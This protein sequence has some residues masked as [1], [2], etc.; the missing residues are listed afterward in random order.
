MHKK[1]QQIERLT[2]SLARAAIIRTHKAQLA[3]QRIYKP[4]RRM[5]QDIKT[6][7]K[8]LK[9]R[10]AVGF[11]ISLIVVAEVIP[12]F[13]AFMNEKAYAFED[14][15]QLL[16]KTSQAMA[17]KL[18][19]NTAEQTFNFNANYSLGSDPKAGGAK[20]IATAHVDPLKG[21]NVSDPVNKT[22]FGLKP[23]FQL[24]QGEKRENRVVYPLQN[25]SG[26]LVYSMEA[27][28]VKEDILLRYA[29]DNKMKFEYELDFGDS[30]EA[31]LEQD[32]SI[33][34]YG[35]SLPI[36]GSVSTGSDKDVEL[37][38]K[39]RQNAKKDKLMFTIPAPFIKETNKT[40]SDIKSHYE[41]KGKLLTL[42]VDGL[43]KGNYPLTIDPS[44]YVTSAEQFMYG[45]NDSNIEFDTSTALIQKGNLT[46][47]RI[48][49]WQ[50]NTTNMNVAIMDNAVTV[51]GGYVYS[52][53]G[54]TTGTTAVSTVYW[55]KFSAN[56]S[57]IVSPTPGSSGVCTNFCTNS[58]Y[59][60]PVQIRG[61]SLV[62]YNGYLYY[63][64][65]TVS[66]NS[67]TAIYK[68][69]IG[70][71]GEPNAWT[72]AGQ[73][74][75]ERSI[76]GAIAYNNRLYVIGGASAIDVVTYSSVVSAPINP[77]GSLGAWTTNT[78]LPSARGGHGVVQY[79]GYIYSI[80]GFN[81]NIDAATTDVNYIKINADGSLAPAWVSTTPLMTP[82]ST[83]GGNFATL[84]N[85]YLYV[86][87]G[88]TSWVVYYACNSSNIVSSLHLASFNADGSLTSWSD[89]GVTR[90]VSS[91]GFV[92]WRGSLYMLGGCT[93]GSTYCYSNRTNA[94]QYGV[95]N[96]AG[97]V[98]TINTGTTLPPLGTNAGQIGR[99][100]GG[101]VVNNGFIY[102]VGGCQ[103]T[104]NCITTSDNTAYA[105]INSNGSIGAW[106]VVNNLNL[107]SNVA[108][109]ITVYNN[110]IY[111]VGGRSA[112]TARAT[113]RS[114]GL[115]A[116]GSLNGNW[117]TASTVLTAAYAYPFAFAREK[118]GDASRFYLYAIGGC[119]GTSG[120]GCSSYR[121]DVRRC[122]INASTGALITGCT[123]S[124]LQLGTATGI[125]GGT[126]YGNYIYLAGGANGLDTTDVSIS[127][128]TCNADPNAC[129]GQTD[130]IQYAM[131]NSS[132][133]ITRNDGTTTTGG[134]HVA[135]TRLDR[136]RRRT[137][138][139]A[140]NGYLYVVGGHDGST[141]TA[142]LQDI[143]RGKINTTTGDVTMDPD[144]L[145][146]TIS[147][148]W[149]LSAVAAN[150]YIYALGGCNDGE[151]PT[152]CSTLN[153]TVEYTQV[154]NN[155]SGSPAS[156]T[157]QSAGT[158]LADRHA[159]SATVNNGYLYVAG[160]CTSISTTDCTAY[161][162]N[163][164]YVPIDANGGITTN[165]LTGPVLPDSRAKG[166]LVTLGNTLYYIGGQNAT[167]G[168]NSAY[169]T[170]YYST[171]T[172]GVPGAWATAT[173]GLPAVR[174]EMGCATYSNKIYVGG[175][176]NASAV[177]YNSVA[178]SPSLPSGGNI[179]TAW[180]TSSNVFPTARAGAT[181]IAYGNN[182]Y[183]LGGFDGTNYLLDVQ[184]ALINSDGTIGTWTR[185]TT[186]PQ[187]VRQ[188]DGFAANGYLY[189]FGGRSAATTCT[190]N[191]YVA[192]INANPI[193]NKVVQQNPN[194]LGEW[195]QTSVA[196]NGARHGVAAA[197][198]N[199]RAYLIGG[200]CNGVYTNANR[201]V[202]GT[203][204]SQ[205]QIA[206]Y[207]YMVDADND[208][209]P[210]KILANGI[211][212][213]IGARWL[214]SYRSSQS[215]TNAWGQ[216]TNAGVVTLGTPGPYTA[217]NG[218]GTNTQSARYYYISYTIDASQSFGYPEDSSRGPTIEDITLQLSASPNKRLRNGKTFT[219][220]QQ[221][222]LDT[223]F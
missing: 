173:N 84:Y 59:N 203:M 185:S 101:V 88:C 38:Q 21:V 48:P 37:L 164:S 215:A 82:R 118:P 29:S 61:G 154:Y 12:I 204:Q 194:P 120:I 158:L 188:G 31:R 34:V 90:S 6:L 213:G 10:V 153:G 50:S 97:D 199:G 142:T 16:P 214:L 111:V 22:D 81:Q 106:T 112:N 58:A 44:V 177:N 198:D 208:V 130:L 126:T 76:P 156:Y 135:S 91:M 145:T 206:R 102:Y 133:V 75:I 4:G 155:W 25:G 201:V 181:V 11:C 87:G 107:D 26:W 7:F 178:I 190:A 71:N 144:A 169:A 125:F 151:P 197:F 207:S 53:G 104:G 89:T 163:V 134:W 47:A 67:Q 62:A 68:S 77:D 124:G 121:S 113:M 148:R 139:F 189:V 93:T 119:V 212:S 184:Y 170:V 168:A 128:N 136:E 63:I 78:S 15:Q 32:G 187:P 191:T 42:H 195:S 85:G 115:N 171:L 70:A 219:S 72:L 109:G 3:A 55:G 182:L 64:G 69:K 60:L 192:P 143:G 146:T 200:M 57:S 103:V 74:D 193:V 117:S 39:A 23:K 176:A 96:P 66:T 223:P 27:G 20:I 49:S 86:A 141:P 79:N 149:D 160:G 140:I 172:N 114:I 116:D 127:G 183:V 52:A 150:G 110:R 18:Q 73:M 17:D 180:A 83:L 220:G 137:T 105:Q 174:A 51:A 218:A 221:Q 216:S 122:E 54:S 217:V 28:Q 43:S 129:G 131:I 45:N 92:A 132:G 196:Y 1:D 162:N 99:M 2:R 202:Y 41:L 175:G 94:V 30:L 19:L 167:T 13:N 161:T 14:P 147:Q 100:A 165:W 5:K 186:L 8:S 98:S 33:A 40:K 123:T 166:C 209:V 35:T 205:P 95:I 222:P 9:R 157:S 56:G 65:G 80:G 152:S 159:A 210:S 36:N 138:A 46:G 211:D 24:K 179:T 108:M